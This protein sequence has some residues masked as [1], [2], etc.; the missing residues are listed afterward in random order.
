MGSK[1][2]PTVLMVHQAVFLGASLAPP[3]RRGT[4]LLPRCRR[5]WRR[6]A[7]PNAVMSGSFSYPK[8]LVHMKAHR[9]RQCTTQH[10]TTQHN[11]TQHNTTKDKKTQPGNLTTG[12]PPSRCGGRLETRWK[13]PRKNQD[14]RTSSNSTSPSNI[15][16]AT[17][18]HIPA[19]Q[20]P[21]DL[22]RNFW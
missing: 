8:V 19:H 11:T 18:A 1:G 2:W 6:R 7:R 15:C 5:A 21:S 3:R 20:N 22:K 14:T 17:A 10:N 13:V 9:E 16:Q 12:S 4:G